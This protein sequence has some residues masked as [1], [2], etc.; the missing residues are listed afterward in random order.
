M[1]Q[2]RVLMILAF[3]GT[4]CNLA[5]AGSSA[6]MVLFVTRYLQA[7]IWSFGLLYSCL[8]IGGAIGAILA[9]KIFQC[10]WNR[11]NFTIH[12]VDHA[13]TPINF[14]YFTPPHGL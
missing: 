8:A 2:S 13:N 14:S 6:I 11:T 5:L 1:L 7:P 9:P 3:N 10:F 12:A 4:L